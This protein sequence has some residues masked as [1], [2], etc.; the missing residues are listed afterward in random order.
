[1]P[2]PT[3]LQR[4]NLARVV[5]RE[6]VP[7]W[8]LFALAIA[9]R[10]AHHAIMWRADPLYGVLLSGADNHTFDRWALE[11]SQTFWL[12]WDRIPFLHGRRQQSV[13]GRGGKPR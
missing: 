11:I 13:P 9:V 2:E 1:M 12:G 4:V 8:T 6:A 3:L 5:S 7:Y 10:L